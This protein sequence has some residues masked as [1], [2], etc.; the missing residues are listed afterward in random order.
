[1]CGVVAGVGWRS[2]ISGFHQRE[3]RGSVEGR[4]GERGSSPPV[5]L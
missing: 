1:V 4:S 3:I 5:L 2:W